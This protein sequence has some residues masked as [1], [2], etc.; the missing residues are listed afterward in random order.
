M[1]T[2]L[3]TPELLIDVAGPWVGMLTEAGFEIR[4]P[5]DRTFT[6]GLSD[7]NATIET[8]SGADAVIAGGEHFTR[9]VLAKLPDLRVVARCGVG[10]DRVDLDAATSHGIPVTITPTANHE[11]V[12]EQA[13]ALMFA[14]A[15][16][17]VVNDQCTR[18]GN[19]RMTL[20][21][22]IR[23]KTFGV[24]GLGRI[25]QSA[26][27]RAIGMG[28]RV[29]AAETFPNEEFV[30]R[31]GVELVDFDT[32]LS[33]SDYLSI[34]CPLTAETIG[35]FNRDVFSRMKPGSVLINTA[36]GKIVVEADLIDALKN[37]PLFGAG[38]DVMEIEPASADNPL[39]ALDN[40]V[41]SPHVA[42][43]DKASM[44][45]MAVEAADCILQLHR[46]EWPSA[47]V[48]NGKLRESWKW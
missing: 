39:F 29:I 11:S 7:E 20:A 10:Y 9:S 6:R 18:Q 31:H 41:V 44:E 13:F 45:A 47:A 24:F 15:K 48:L 1:P 19:W 36:R 23:G 30:R 40:V 8:L 32:L 35:L 28:M 37:G 34:H 43:T 46:G 17:V 12:A 2:V 14:V 16:S 21:E 22:P 26:A 42:G 5:A 3:I 27:V 33:Q 25:G 38:L 4:Y